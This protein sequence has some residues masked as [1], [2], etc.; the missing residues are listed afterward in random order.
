MAPK[1]DRK[2]LLI[3]KMKIEIYYDG[4][5]IENN[6]G[7]EVKGF[8][9]NISFLKA[10]GVS[11]YERFIKNSLTYS[12]GRPISFQLFDEDDADIISTAR[13]ICSYDPSI[14]VKIPIIK[15]N[16]ESNASV[17][18]QLHEEGLKINVTA[19][20]TEEQIAS[21]STVFKYS[22]DAIVSVF[23]G[24]VNDCGIDCSDLVKNSVETFKNFPNIK[25]L[26]AACRTVYNII[27]AEQQGAHIVTVPESVL[28]RTFRLKQS[29]SFASLETV[30]QFREDGVSSNLTL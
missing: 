28:S 27:E 23:G 14:F 12:K 11:N 13:K 10:A 6:C 3:N 20:F 19:I 18:R 24:R 30:R 29:P 9:T 16:G 5:E 15:S 25:I 1:R 7:E 17:I 8:T 2:K 26:W 21:I 4:T 22:T